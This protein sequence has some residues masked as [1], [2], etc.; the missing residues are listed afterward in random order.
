MQFDDGYVKLVKSSKL[1]KGKLQA[2]PLF[3]PVT[4]SKQER[5][6]RKRKINIAALFGKKTRTAIHEEKAGS[7]TSMLSPNEEPENWTPT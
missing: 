5:R 7:E 3:E 1:A 6:D 2:S 4:S